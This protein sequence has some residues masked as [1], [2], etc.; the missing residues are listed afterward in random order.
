MNCKKKKKFKLYK[1]HGK[2]NWM[3]KEMADHFG[4]CI[5]ILILSTLRLELNWGLFFFFLRVSYRQY[6]NILTL[7]TRGC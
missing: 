7:L 6:A 4:M 3:C 2:M 5:F 1:F